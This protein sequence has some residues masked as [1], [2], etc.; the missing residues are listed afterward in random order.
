MIDLSRP[1]TTREGRPALVYTTE[2]LHPH[3]PLHGAYEVEP[4]VWVPA[5]WTR[6]GKYIPYRESRRDLINPPAHV[7][8]IRRTVWLNI[9]PETTTTHI[10]AASARVA[11][12][13]GRLAC[14]S[15]LVDCVE[16][17]GL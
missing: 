16:G 3:Y 17:E 13:A 11:A 15:V 9:Y 2:A 1:V 6:D 5:S 14:I 10:G 12:C 4:E 8:R 7:C